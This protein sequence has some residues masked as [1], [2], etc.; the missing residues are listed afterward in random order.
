P[1]TYSTSKRVLDSTPPSFS[2]A[3]QLSFAEAKINLSWAAATDNQSTTEPGSDIFFEIYRKR[4]GSFTNPLDPTTDAQAAMMARVAQSVAR[5]WTDLGTDFISGQP[6]FYT[7]CAVDA[8]GN[9]KCDGNVKDYVIPDLLPP[10]ITSFTTNKGED[11]Y[12]WTLSWVAADVV[13]TA[14]NLLYKIYAKQSNVESDT[15]TTGDTVVFIQTGTSTF[16]G[17]R[18]PINK[19]VYIHYLL[20]VEDADGNKASKNLTV[21]SQNKVTLATVRSTEGLITGNTKIV[22]VGDGLKPDLQ[23]KIGESDCQ[24]I[25][26][27]SKKHVICRT[28]AGTAGSVNVRVINAD[29][30]SATLA[31]AYV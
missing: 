12:E 31:N 8:T 30:S 7:V 17:V 4:G 19:D 20:V 13:T 26:R 15:A 10:T 1:T 22:I 14:P 11:D 21:Y 3:L 2:S 5:T 6:Y 25:V 9:R 29:G 23:V 27:Y 18:G 28:P 24:S 16:A